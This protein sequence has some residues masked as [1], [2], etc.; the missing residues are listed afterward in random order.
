MEE[1]KAHLGHGSNRTTS[2]TYGHL[3]RTAKV[4]LADALKAMFQTSRRAD[5]GEIRANNETQAL[6]NVR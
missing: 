3:F 4:A 1:V 5:T 6:R 2:D